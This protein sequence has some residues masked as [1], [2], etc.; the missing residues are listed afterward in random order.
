MTSRVSQARASISAALEKRWRPHDIGRGVQVGRHVV[1][2]LPAG[3]EVEEGAGDLPPPEERPVPVA[4][5][6]REPL[7]EAR[8]LGGLLVLADCGGEGPCARG[9]SRLMVSRSGS[10]ER[11][12]SVQTSARRL[13]SPSK[14]P[15]EEGHHAVAVARGRRRQGGTAAGHRDEARGRP[16]TVPLLDERGR[17]LQPGRP[18]GGQAR[19]AGELLAAPVVAEDD[20]LPFGAAGRTVGGEGVETPLGRRDEIPLHRLHGVAVEMPEEEAG[21]QVGEHRQQQE[22]QRDRQHAEQEVGEGEPASDL[23]EE[24]AVGPPEPPDQE[25]HPAA[26]EQDAGE[27][28][29]VGDV[30]QRDETQDREGQEEGQEAAETFF[31][32]DGWGCEEA[33]PKGTTGCRGQSFPGV[34][35]PPGSAEVGQPL[36]LP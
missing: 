4:V 20:V 31:H 18:D 17:Q 11:K 22:E 33:S 36:Q 30:R 35:R 28:A 2:H 24:G 8:R 9:S 3:G 32:E 23:P 5:A 26:G 29:Q 1:G 15:A 7:E 13:T 14:S 16:Q 21:E 34:R 6:A 12:I 19:V 25:R 10:S 27:D